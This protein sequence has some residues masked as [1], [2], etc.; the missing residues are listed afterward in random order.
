M[1]TNFEEIMIIEKSQIQRT[2]ILPLL[3]CEVPR[4]SQF[5]TTESRMAAA[6]GWGNGN[7][8]CLMFIKFLMAVVKKFWM[9]A[10]AAQHSECAKCCSTVHLRTNFMYIYHTQKKCLTCT[11]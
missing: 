2:N 8:Y 4:T 5:M 6:R 9:V 10:T 3:L 11:T 7:V 1:W